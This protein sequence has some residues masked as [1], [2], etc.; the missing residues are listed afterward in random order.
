MRVII[1]QSL[2]HEIQQP[3]FPILALNV[4]FEVRHSQGFDSESAEF[5]SPDILT[6]R[7]T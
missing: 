2:P 1:N 5:A 7:V 3:S 4:G 6:P